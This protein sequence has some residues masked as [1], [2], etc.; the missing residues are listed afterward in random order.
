MLARYG[1][2]AAITLRQTRWDAPLGRLGQR[3]TGQPIGRPAAAYNATEYEA[4]VYWNGA[5]FFLALRDEL[6]ERAFSRLLRAYAERY[7]WRIAAPAEFRALAE[8]I[9]GR[10]LDALF[11]KWV[12]QG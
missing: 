2:P 9:A 4:V 3:V 5:R 1:V 10:K 7:R 8:E 6:G 11:T 12:G